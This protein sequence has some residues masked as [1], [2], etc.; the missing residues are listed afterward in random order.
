MLLKYMQL[1]C[2]ENTVRLY[3]IIVNN[4]ITLSLYNLGHSSG[5]IFLF[6]K[7]TGK[8]NPK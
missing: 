7:N 3:V 4:S 8:Y 1:V 2:L 5:D 6:T